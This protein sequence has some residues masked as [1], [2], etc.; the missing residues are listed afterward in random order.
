MIIHLA[1]DFLVSI[2]YAATIKQFIYKTKS[3]LGNEIIEWGFSMI[4]F[5]THMS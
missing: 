2:D 3:I 4:L 5:P 1:F